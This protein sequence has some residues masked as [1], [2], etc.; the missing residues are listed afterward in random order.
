MLPPAPTPDTPLP[1]THDILLTFHARLNKIIEDWL[2]RRHTA[3][4]P[5]EHKRNTASAN[6]LLD[7]WGD[8]LESYKLD[9]RVRREIDLFWLYAKMCVNTYAAKEIWDARDMN[10]RNA[11]QTMNVEAA[12]RLLEKCTE[13]S[14]RE[15]LVNLPNYYFSVS[16]LTFTKVDVDVD[17]RCL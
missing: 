2:V 6:A 17:D 12:V 14:P 9:G 8:E 7:L 5:F 11:R 4:S 3:V 10:V 15:D 16:I 13:W 1:S